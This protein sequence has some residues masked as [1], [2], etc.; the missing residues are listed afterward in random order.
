MAIRIQHNTR[1]G[2]TYE[3][4]YSRITSLSINYVSEYADVTICIYRSELDRK[5]GKDPVSQ[6][7]IRYT[8][9]KFETFFREVSVNKI[10]AR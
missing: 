7:N 8:G 1:F 4:A 9:E 2:D 6:E 3:E 5:Y 10:D